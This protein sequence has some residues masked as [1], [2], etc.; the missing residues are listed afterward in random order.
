MTDDQNKKRANLRDVAK[1]AGVSVATVSRVLNA[2]DA[3]RPKTREKVES[4]IRTLRF[5][6]S[7]AARAINSGRTRFVGALVPTLDNAIF[8]R[9]LA[10]LEHKL[11]DHRL[12]LVVA[13]TYNDPAIEV[14]KA[15]T[16]VD[17]GA[18]GLIVSGITHDPA[19][20]DLIERCQLPTIATSYHDP[21]YH[22]PTVGYDNMAATALALDY[23]A[24]QGHRD[25]A[26]V[27]GPLANN[28]RTRARMAGL[29]PV[30]H[31]AQLQFFETEIAILG[32]CR[33]ASAILAAPRRVSAILCFSDV[34]ALGVLF[35]LQRNAVRVPDD[36]SLMGIDDLAAS[37]H[38]EPGLTTVHLPVSRMGETSA[39]AV[40]GWIETQERPA[41]VL[42]VPDRVIRGSPRAVEPG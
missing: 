26:V 17:V 35:E 18:E 1:S 7:A 19:L 8:A 41:P 23:L 37:A 20:D 38:S 32:G 10:A 6:P 25:I 9:F 24:G 31:A 34:L 22:L 36:L 5:V 33:A 42:L 40:A 11:L 21:S 14:E 28:D 15:K 4:A 29:D 13:N 27:H 16:L 2:P 39:N 12:S 30:G 3:V